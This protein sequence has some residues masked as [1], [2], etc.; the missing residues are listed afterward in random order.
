MGILNITTQYLLEDGRIKFE[1]DNF[2]NIR[3][4]EYNQDK[5][6]QSI[7]WSNNNISE[8]YIYKKSVNGNL[9]LFCKYTDN[10]FSTTT[11]KY[12]KHDR[13]IFEK[14]IYHNDLSHIS[15]SWY[16][17]NK[18]G[19]CTSKVHYLFYDEYY[20]PTYLRS[21]MLSANTKQDVLAAYNSAIKFTKGIVLFKADSIR[22]IADFI[23]YKYDDSGNIIEEYSADHKIIYTYD[24][25]NRVISEK[26]YWSLIDDYE[27]CYE[28]NDDNNIVTII[29]KDL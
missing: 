28:Y 14:E 20:Y 10:G 23:R 8:K 3:H 5:S 1:A 9:L 7:D 12:D 24:D 6:L 18:S 19:K 4:Y 25:K 26:Y 17:Y 29:K 16:N 27:T 22:D 13:L 11:Y 2:G 21:M 15:F